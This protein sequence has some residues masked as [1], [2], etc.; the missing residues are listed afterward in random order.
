MFE[1]V[2]RKMRVFLSFHISH[3][4]NIASNAMALFAWLF[5]TSCP[6]LLDG[7]HSVPTSWINIV[8]AKPI[9]DIGPHSSSGPALEKKVGR[10]FLRLVAKLAYYI[11]FSIHMFWSKLAQK[12]T[13]PLV[14]KLS[15]NSKTTCRKQLRNSQLVLP[16]HLEIYIF[17]ITFI[18]SC[19]KIYNFLGN[20]NGLLDKSNSI[21]GRPASIYFDSLKNQKSWMKF[22]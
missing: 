1:A 20:C 15:G 16:S 6:P 3:E 10:G 7:M 17:V 14:W 18:K 21:D 13:C 11:I 12:F 4:T 9:L 8:K 5:F 19:L 2:F 22:G